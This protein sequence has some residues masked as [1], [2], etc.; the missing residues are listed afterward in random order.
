M[1]VL[2]RLA[3][4]INLRLIH[5]SKQTPQYKARYGWPGGL[6]SKTA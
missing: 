1:N 6:R 4:V 2:L 3:T 5:T